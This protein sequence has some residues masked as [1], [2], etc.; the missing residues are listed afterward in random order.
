MSTAFDRERSLEFG[1]DLHCLGHLFRIARLHYAGGFCGSLVARP[2]TVEKSLVI[3][4]CFVEELPGKQLLQAIYLCRRLGECQRLRRN[5]LTAPSPSLDM[6][7][8]RSLQALVCHVEP[9]GSR[10]A[11]AV[12]YMTFIVYV[13]NSRLHREH[14]PSRL[15]SQKWN[16]GSLETPIHKACRNVR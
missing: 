7:K 4:A 6:F 8:A 5:I 2:E 9:N 15:A 14:E 16:Q 1:A 10:V 11:G 12:C 13:F 3:R